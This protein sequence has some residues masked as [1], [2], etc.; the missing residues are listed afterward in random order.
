MPT[1][2]HT[3]TIWREEPPMVVVAEVV[4]EAMPMTMSAPNRA[5]PI[6][7]A[8]AHHT[9]SPTHHA[10]T[11][12]EDGEWFDGPHTIAITPARISGTDPHMGRP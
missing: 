8:H 1:R 3:C 12:R 10:M 11:R 9:M 5:R 7:E 2:H 4:A 6:A